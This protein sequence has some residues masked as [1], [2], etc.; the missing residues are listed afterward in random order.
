MIELI[1]RNWKIFAIVWFLA[2]LAGFYF[3]PI[4]KVS[5]GT[6]NEKPVMCEQIEVAMEILKAKGETPLVTG[7]Q[8]A[9]VRSVDGLATH[10]VQ[11]PLQIF[12]NINTKTFSI[13]EYHPAI[14]S[15]CVIAYGDDFKLIGEKS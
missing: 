3:G 10:P 11:I 13:L 4:N 15:V 5:A 1:K 14:N 9:K 6:W 7:V 8:H 2:F 12:V